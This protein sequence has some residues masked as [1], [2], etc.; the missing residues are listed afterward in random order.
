MPKNKCVKA[1]QIPPNKSHIIFI[2]VDRQPVFEEVSEIFTP[3]GASPT[4]AN[5]KHWRPNGIP[6]IVRH[7]INPPIRYSKKIKIPPKIIHK[8][9]PKKFI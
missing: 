4:N 2:T 1:I 6:T 5:L 9:L 8:I 7:N 3:N